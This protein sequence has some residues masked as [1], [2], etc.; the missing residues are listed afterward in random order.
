ML[1]Q[2]GGV[3]AGAALAATA[4]GWPLPALAAPRPTEAAGGP[5]LS[6][7]GWPIASEANAGQAVWTRPVSGTGFTLDTR[8]GRAETVLVHVVRRWHYE[9]ETLRDGEVTGW[10]PIGRLDADSPESNLA[11][12]TAVAI[13]PGAYPRGT[14]G[15]LLGW[16]ERTVRDILADCDGLV[17]WGGDDEVPYEALFYLDTPLP[18]DSGHPAAG[19]ELAGL[20]SRIRGWNAAPGRGA[21]R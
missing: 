11:S 8:I 18:R 20:E 7:N 1:K 2:L 5:L 16:Q 12:G 21:G 17:R 19:G 10:T 13:R 14:R 4:G 9:I 15:N 3:S 6:A